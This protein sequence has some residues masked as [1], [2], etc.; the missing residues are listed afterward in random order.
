MFNLLIFLAFSVI[1]LPL[2]FIFASKL[3]LLGLQ[4][5]KF[6]NTKSIVDYLILVFI[7]STIVMLIVQL[8][9]ML[10]FYLNFNF[11]LEEFSKMEISN[12][13][14]NYYDLD[15][16]RFWPSCLPQ[17]FGILAAML[18]VH[19]T[20]PGAPKVKIAAALASLGLTVPFTIINFAIENPNRFNRLIYFWIEYFNEGRWPSNVP[21][22][23]NDIQVE[24]I[25]Q[26]AAQK[27]V[28]ETMRRLNDSNSNS[29]SSNSTSNSFLPEDFSLDSFFPDFI[30]KYILDIFRPLP[31]EGYLDDIIAQHLFIHL[32]L[33]IVVIS[34]MVLLTIFMVINIT[35]QNKDFL[36][37]RFNNKYI[38]F[39][40]KY[41][42]ILGKIS[43]IVLPLLLLLGL[44]ELAIGL[45]YI[46]THPIPLEQ[47]PIDLHTY[48]KKN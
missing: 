42:I 30:S 43:I 27:T 24:V 18:A 22:I 41:Q 8:I 25:A 48:I 17:I 14:N 10:S 21:S 12:S 4:L 46:I 37:K 3:G 15:Q 20:I 33:L 16:V 31:V 19:K 11:K 47:L 9:L 6:C 23:F 39:Y 45:H 5:K 44:I 1:L 28:E 13:K 7:F 2:L 29:S 34:S 38:L 35:L 36:I 40:I 32:L 26:R